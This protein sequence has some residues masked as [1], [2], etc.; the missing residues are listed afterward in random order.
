LEIKQRLGVN[1][2]KALNLFR[3]QHNGKRKK[4]VQGEGRFARDQKDPQARSEK[5]SQQKAHG[6]KV[7]TDLR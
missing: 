1:S 2:A 3:R 7:G 6:K 4:Q 5:A